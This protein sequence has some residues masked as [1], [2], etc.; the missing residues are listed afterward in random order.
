M[1]GCETAMSSIVSALRWLAYNLAP[2]LCPECSGFLTPVLRRTALEIGAALPHTDPR[3][4]LRSDWLCCEDCD[5]AVAL[6]I[7]AERPR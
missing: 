4:L 6:D 1:T 7:S 5:Y 3:R 2:P